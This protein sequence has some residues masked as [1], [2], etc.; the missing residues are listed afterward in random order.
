MQYQF[1]GSE[2]C[3]TPAL[4]FY[5]DQILEN[6]R[7][8]IAM[9]GSAERLWPHMKTHK[10]PQVLKLLRELGISSDTPDPAGGH[11]GRD[12]QGC[13]TG[14]LEENALI[15]R[16]RQI[17]RPTGYRGAR[18]TRSPGQARKAPG[19]STSICRSSSRLRAS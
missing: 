18:V 7:R 2:Q 17:P 12:A 14:Y 15:L 10:C 13:L 11:I 3:I 1:S 6:T 8:A 16:T 5:P 19:S 9:A 4:V